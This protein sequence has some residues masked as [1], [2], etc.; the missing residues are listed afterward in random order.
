MLQEESRKPLF[1]KVNS[2]KRFKESGVGGERTERSSA[3]AWTGVQEE[4]KASH[5]SRHGEQR[6]MTGFVKIQ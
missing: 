1:S 2:K 6:R 3:E 4:E 5:T